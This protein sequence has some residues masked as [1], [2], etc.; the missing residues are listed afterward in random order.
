[1]RILASIIPLLVL[2]GVRAGDGPAYPDTCD[3]TEFTMCGDQCIYF[4]DS[5]YCGSDT[6]IDL[7]SSDDEHCCLESDETCTTDV[8]GEVERGR[9]HCNEGRKVSMSSACNTTMGPRCYNSYQHS[10]YISPQSHYTC[11][12]TCVPWE[13]M[14]RG[15]SQCEGE[16]QVC[17]PDLRCPA[18]GVVKKL[19]V[20]KL[21]ISSSLVASHHYCIDNSSKF[22]DGQFDSIDRSD[23]TRVTA[24]QS[25]LDLD[26]SSFTPCNTAGI[27]NNYPG[28]MC[29]K[30]C[31]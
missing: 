1:M 23:E 6:D 13:E 11:P 22:N 12:D 7:Y 10:Q 15:L 18:S 27:F 14:C 19:Y 8:V 25:P 20:K 4:R 21:N 29:G 5:C 17:G 16:H 3:Y 2:G 28:V 26:I 9:G 31:R 30:D 24:A